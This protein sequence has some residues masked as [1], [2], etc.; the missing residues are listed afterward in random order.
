MS[1]LALNNRPVLSGE[2]AL[3]RE[4][5]RDVMWEIRTFS[6][7]QYPPALAIRAE[8]GLLNMAGVGN[9]L[10]SVVEISNKARP[11]LF[12]GSHDLLEAYRVDFPRSETYHI[13]CRRCRVSM[14]FDIWQTLPSAE[15]SDQ[16]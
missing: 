9:K 1:A 5:I 16:T 4:L 2:R 7:H 12:C 15:P 11:C 14:P 13:E 6:G 8:N 10:A 3:R